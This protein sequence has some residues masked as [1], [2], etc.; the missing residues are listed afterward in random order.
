MREY[1]SK[2]SERLAKFEEAVYKQ[3]EEM[4]EKMAE[5]MSLLKEFSKAKAPE[6][7]L[8]RKGLEALNAKPVI[9]ISTTRG[10]DDIE[11]GKFS[12]GDGWHFVG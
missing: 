11:K 6:K 8:M 1:T 4:E 10:G 5:M 2:H 9:S 7:V 12:T 3:K